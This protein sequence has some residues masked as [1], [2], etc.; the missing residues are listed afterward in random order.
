MYAYKSKSFR[1]VYIIPNY[2][3]QIQ[4]SNL[5]MGRVVNTVDSNQKFDSELNAVEVQRLRWAW[6]VLNGISVLFEHSLSSG[7]LVDIRSFSIHTFP[8][9][10]KKLISTLYRVL[11]NHEILIKS[12]IA[13]YHVTSYF[14]CLIVIKQTKSTCRFVRILIDFRV[15]KSVVT[16]FPCIVYVDSNKG[17]M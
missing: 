13:F 8:L 9:F 3:T 1:L 6:S 16:S 15:K 11:N 12:H 2:C 5:C 17:N 14:L 7:N 4:K 10:Y